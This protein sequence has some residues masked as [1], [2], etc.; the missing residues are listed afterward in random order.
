MESKEDG[1]LTV[2]CQVGGHTQC[3]NIIPMTNGGTQ[4]VLQ[5][6]LKYHVDL[7]VRIWALTVLPGADKN[8]PDFMT[9]LNHTAP[10]TQEQRPIIL[11]ALI[12]SDTHQH[13]DRGLYTYMTSYLAQAYRLSI[14]IDKPT[15]FINS[16]LIRLSVDN[17]LLINTRSL[18]I[19]IDK[20]I[21]LSIGISNISTP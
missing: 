21:P 4:G 10:R 19:V 7:N 20:P 1:S 9:L 12:V 18:S 3:N 13:I 2:T 15:L 11:D 17:V 8:P 5:Y 16:W 14:L 6:F